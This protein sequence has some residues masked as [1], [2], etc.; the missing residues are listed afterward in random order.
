MR[1]HRFDFP[2][3]GPQAAVSVRPKPFRRWAEWGWHPQAGCPDAGS[4]SG[5]P[6]RREVP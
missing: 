4:G 1:R 3:G 5:V 6:A 2:D